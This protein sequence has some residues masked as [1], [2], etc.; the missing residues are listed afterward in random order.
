MPIPSTNQGVYTTTFHE[1][2]WHV[3]VLEPNSSD[4]M[5]LNTTFADEE[6]AKHFMKEQRRRMQ[7]AS[8]KAFMLA[9]QS[10]ELILSGKLPGNP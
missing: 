7:F 9:K 10:Q 6:D 5:E 4:I 1:G 8:N 3:L 2:R